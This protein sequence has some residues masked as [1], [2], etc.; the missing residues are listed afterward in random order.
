MPGN[1]ASS[2]TNCFN[3]NWGRASLK[4]RIWAGVGNDEYDDELVT[5]FENNFPVDRRGPDDGFFYAYDYGPADSWR[6]ISLNSMCAVRS[7]TGTD[8]GPDETGVDMACLEKML[9]WLDT[10]FSQN[11]R[12]CTIALFHHPRFSSAIGADVQNNTVRM[13]GLWEHLARNGV[14]VA[15]SAHARNYERFRPSDPFGRFDADGMRSF[16]VGTGGQTP[17]N[18]FAASPHPLSAARIANTFGIAR[19]TLSPGSYD[20]AFLPV[21][22]APT[23]TGTSSCRPDSPPSTTATLK[24]PL[25]DQGSYIGPVEISLD[26]SDDFSDDPSIAYRL[27]G[28]EWNTYVGPFG[29]SEEGAHLVEFRGTDPVGHAEEI[30]S[31]TFSIDR[32]PPSI[33]IETQR[34][35]L[36][37]PNGKL[38]DV[39]LDIT[40][41]ASVRSTRVDLTSSEPV[42]EVG[43]DMVL[44]EETQRLRLR[45]ERFDGGPGRTYTVSVTATDEAGNQSVDHAT[46]FVPHDLGKPRT[47][48]KGPRG[49]EQIAAVPGPD[50]EAPA[51]VKI[52]SS[53][54]I[55]FG[56][57]FGDRVGR[58]GGSIAACNMDDEPLDELVVGQGPG[59][60]NGSD[61]RILDSDGSLLRTLEDVL[62]S[63]DGVSLACGDVDGDDFEDIIAISAS[64]GSAALKVISRDGTTRSTFVPFSNSDANAWRVATAD[65]KN[66]GAEEIVVA[67]AGPTAPSTVKVFDVD[68]ALRSSFSAFDMDG[69]VR[70]AG[71]DVLGDDREEIVTAPGPRVLSPGVIRTFRDDGVKVAEFF[72]PDPNL[73]LK[74]YGYHHAHD[75]RFGFDL[76]E[77]ASYTNWAHFG[78]PA[79]VSETERRGMRSILELRLTPDESV[80]EKRVE[81]ARNQLTTSDL[82]SISA[83]LVKDQADATGWDTAK[84][85]RALDVTATYFPDEIPRMMIYGDQVSGAYP[86]TS[87][88]D[89]LDWVGVDSFLPDG[90]D[91]E[92]CA[93][94]TGFESGPLSQLR[95][96]SNWAEQTADADSRRVVVFAPSFRDATRGLPS[97]CQQSWFMEA[98]LGEVEVVGLVWFMHGWAQGAGIEGAAMFDPSLATDLHRKLFDNV[99]FGAWGAQ[100]ALGDINDDGKDEIAVSRGEGSAN[101]TGYSLYTASG[102]AAGPTRTEVF[103]GLAYGVNLAFGRFFEPPPLR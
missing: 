78:I 68:G 1:R 14:D 77:T 7:D 50:P 66:D 75:P 39:G 82:Q 19:F 30:K 35:T 29:V 28:G 97:L 15:I 22:G 58:H 76:Y 84:Q 5:T 79:F 17:F 32:S 57:A 4:E 44:D 49:D 45:A 80:W 69:G 55:E 96:A 67:P 3:S 83:I 91:N 73:H 40:T 38:V 27:N 25:T 101:G 85:Q 88:P 34:M 87:P 13:Q 93:G 26:A 54:D 41:D 89:G 63:A 21:G 12:E 86:G 92:G 72:A 94:R 99:R 62:E 51:L 23:D 16:V 90:T 53:P 81:D 64:G 8:S 70:I 33:N 48:T 52:L 61:L 20:W 59:P 9:A 43:P 71:G 95:W 102:E 42:G 103:P 74:H 98:A 36:W 2:Y 31:K 46:V 60:G 10:E 47:V 11:P 18:A 56:D 6:V 37:P 24:G 65:T 100:V